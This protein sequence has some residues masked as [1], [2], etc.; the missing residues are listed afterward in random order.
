LWVKNGT[1]VLKTGEGIKKH[2]ALVGVIFS[3]YVATV[4]AKLLNSN[5]EGVSC[6]TNHFAP[7]LCKS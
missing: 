3:N 4:A 6:R 5:D 7:N 2:D 1:G